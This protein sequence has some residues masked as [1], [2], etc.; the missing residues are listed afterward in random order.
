MTSEGKILRIIDANLNRATEG[1][2]VVEEICRFILEDRQ[3]TLALKKMRGELSTTIRLSERNA[4]GD[5]GREMFTETEGKRE[6]LVAVFKSNMKRAQEAVRCL[7]E[8]SKLLDPRAGKKFKALRFKLYELE[9][10]IAP[11]VIIQDKLDFGIYVITDPVCD[12]IKIA[13]RAFAK[14]VRALQLRDKTISRGEYFSLAKKITGMARRAGAAFILNDYWD[15]VNKVG[16]DGVHLGQEDLARVSLGKVRKEMGE[17]KIIGVSTHSFKQALRAE[18]WGADYISVG[19]IFKTPSKPQACPVGL[20]L[21]RRVLKKVQIPVV[22]IGGIDRNNIG[23]VRKTGCQR[24][25]VIRA[26]EELCRQQ[27]YLGSG[28]F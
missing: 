3:L 18:K 25:A 21:L 9:K 11:L 28:N 24:V 16:A 6:G 19:P 12:H 8:F 22:A 17:D 1:I 5:V 26:A 13:K 14:R 15:M 4:E 10:E 7:E 20:S 23:A 27:T 2:R